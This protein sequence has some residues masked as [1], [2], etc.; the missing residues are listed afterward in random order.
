M[1]SASVY[2]KICTSKTI[3]YLF[4]FKHWKNWSVF[5]KA[6]W[7]LSSFANHCYAMPSSLSF[8][9]GTVPLL[10]FKK[11]KR[12]VSCCDEKLLKITG[13]MKTPNHFGLFSLQYYLPRAFLA[14]CYLLNWPPCLVSRWY[15]RNFPYSLLW[16]S[17]GERKYADDSA[18]MTS[19]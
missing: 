11:S 1:R 18:E 5:W 6:S 2:C 8:S 9:T 14:L 15:F 19:T 13:R 12:I 16:S 3:T 7:S 4:L 17:P 10:F